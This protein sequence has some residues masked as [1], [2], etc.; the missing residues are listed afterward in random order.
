M[1]HA[2]L[3]RA[4]ALHCDGMGLMQVAGLCCGDGG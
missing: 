3:Q 4:L 1:E 2:G